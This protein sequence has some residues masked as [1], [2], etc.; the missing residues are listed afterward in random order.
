[1][2]DSAILPSFTV[3]IESSLSNYRR[4]AQTVNASAPALTSNE[5]ELLVRCSDSSRP[6]WMKLRSL[7]SRTTL[8]FKTVLSA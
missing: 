2:C 7:Y 5:V 1:M 3:L 8:K 6:P 4:F